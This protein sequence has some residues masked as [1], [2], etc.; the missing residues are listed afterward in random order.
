[1][2][3]AVGVVLVVAV[4]V[5]VEVAVGEAVGVAVG[6]PVAV[7]VAVAVFVAVAV[8]VEVAVA[9]D[10]A[11]AVGVAVGPTLAI[12]TDSTARPDGLPSEGAFVPVVVV[13]VV[14]TRLCEPSMGQGRETPP[15]V[16]PCLRVSAP[17]IEHTPV[18]IL[19]LALN[20]SIHKSLE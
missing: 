7:A 6:T 1:M 20:A 10:V 13:T 9:V 5:A 12:A 3:V 17:L 2:A 14:P 4:A 18:A 19:T 16:P 11:V 15:A 8:A